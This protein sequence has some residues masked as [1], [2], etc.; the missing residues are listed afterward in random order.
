MKNGGVASITLDY[1]RPAAAPSHAD[2]RLRIAGTNGVIETALIDNKVTLTTTKTAS[3]SLPLP[4]QIDIFTQFV[5]SLR[6]QSSP[7]LSLREA[8]RITEIA[9]K[10]QQAADTK[11][12]VSLANS[13]YTVA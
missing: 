3:H 6:G 7:P 12:T 5:R 2:E 8:C 9:I 1:L 11:A 4:S 13:P 10:A